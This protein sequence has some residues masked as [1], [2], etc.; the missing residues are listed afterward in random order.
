MVRRSAFT[1][2]Y[3]HPCYEPNPYLFDHLKYVANKT[4]EIISQTNFPETDQNI[5]YCAGLL[6]DIG[7]INPYYQIYFKE[8]KSNEKTQEHCKELGL[9]NQIYFK[10]KK[11]NEE[12]RKQLEKKYGRIH[13][14]Y[15]AWLVQ[16]M[17]KGFSQK[18]LSDIIIL[19]YKHHGALQGSLYDFVYDRPETHNYIKDNLEIFA[20]KYK[21]TQVF[22]K[23]NWDIPDSFFS[24]PIIYD[25]SLEKNKENFFRIGFLFS[26]LL[27]ADKGSFSQ[28][29]YDQFN[30]N[31]NTAKLEK[32]SKLSNLRTEIQK[33][34]AKNYDPDNPISI[35]NAP[36]GTG[37]TKAFLDIVV[38]YGKNYSRVFYFS[39]LLALTEDF[40]S[41]L[42]QCITSSELSGILKYNSVT[43]D[44]LQKDDDKIN[45][46][47]QEESTEGIDKCWNFDYESFNKSFIIT[48]LQ[49][50]LITIYSPKNKDKLKLA[51]FR[52]SLLIVDEIQTVPSEILGNLIEQMRLIAKYLNSKILLVS[53]T[54]PYELNNIPKVAIP[55]IITKNY[56]EETT[57]QISILEDFKI[58]DIT[59]KQFLLMLNTRKKAVNTWRVLH[60]QKTVYITAGITKQDKKNRIDNIKTYNKVISTQVIEAGVDISF[61]KIYR[62]MAPLDNII[63][64]LGRLNRENDQDDS[65]LVIFETDG[66]HR[67]Y[68]KLEYQTSKRYLENVTD[69]KA[70]YD[71]LPIYYEEI[72][73]NNLVSRDQSE[74]L[75]FNV[76][77]MNFTQVWEIVKKSSDSFYDDVFVP[78]VNKWQYTKDKLIQKQFSD[79]NK[80]SATLPISYHDDKVKEF[81]DED[82]LEMQV[83]LPKKD[84]LDE[85]YDKEIGLDKW[86]IQ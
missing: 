45:N 22:D 34:I 69:S 50:L 41:K 63:Q 78:D 48:T 72:Y 64:M 17:L 74:F 2:F 77:N 31:I 60:E 30:I 24:R 3:S 55:D 1:E 5:G 58:N 15:S 85:L 53:A 83:L 68:S 19:I 84:K 54:I 8:K 76:N 79:V 42:T 82:L 67:P 14:P 11:S 49:R 51:S 65:L 9:N 56:L 7:K 21:D 27:Q 73:N 25:V 16:K 10:E 37:K 40:E 86:L 75:S 39:P 26:A 33:Y 29:R 18:Q 80:F 70:L 38:K 43:I 12:L 44:T 71:K 6:H 46:M 4:R 81:W 20:Q 28:H 23:L 59:D 57:K 36:T 62:E 61:S 47:S 35:I 32:S 66:Q 52:N 13:A